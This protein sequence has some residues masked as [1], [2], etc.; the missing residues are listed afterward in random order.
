MTIK[1]NSDDELLLNKKIKYP[2]KAI[3]VRAIFLENNRYYR[4]VFLDECLYEL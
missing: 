3:V 4:Q 1:F 2:G